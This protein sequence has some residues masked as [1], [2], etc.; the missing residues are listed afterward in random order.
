VCV[1]LAHASGEARHPSDFVDRLQEH[2]HRVQ[3]EL[4]LIFPRA[5][6]DGPDGSRPRDLLLSRGDSVSSL[7]ASRGGA[8]GGRAG[9]KDGAGARGG[10]GGG[11]GINRDIQRLFTQKI[12]TFSGVEADAPPLSM[13]RTQPLW[14][15]CKIAF[16]AMME[17]VRME[18][19]ENDNTTSDADAHAKA[20]ATCATSVSA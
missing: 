10:G 15:V 8:G 18:V 2:L 20:E 11:G 14:A 1:Q 7:N 17:T 13:D 12:A 6:E 16:K 5:R 9:G 4:A 3:N 19:D